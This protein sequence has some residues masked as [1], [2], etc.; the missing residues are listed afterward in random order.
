MCNPAKCGHHPGRTVRA[1]DVE[2]LSIIA[3]WEIP[4]TPDTPSR[5]FEPED[6]HYRHLP[7]G[8]GLAYVDGKPCMMD[9]EDIH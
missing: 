3:D 9:S 6:W 8:K 5:L 4:G 1:G 7:A 2:G